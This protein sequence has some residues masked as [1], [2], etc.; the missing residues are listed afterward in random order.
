MEFADREAILSE[1][2]HQPRSSLI[3]RRELIRAA[4]FASAASALGAQFSFAQAIASGLTPAA[5]DED[6]STVLTDPNWK[7]VFLNDHQNE[8]LIAL[9]DVIIPS[10]DTPGATAALVN[11]YLDLLLSVQPVEFQKQ[12][13]DALA[14]IDTESQKQFAKTFPDLAR[15]DQI[16]LL[17]AWAYPSDSDRWIEGEGKADPGQQHFE[18]LKALIAAAFYGSE[19]GLKE[20]GW[21]GEF[22]HGPYEGCEHQPETHI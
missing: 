22:T 10:A 2:G 13:V 1:D 17:S 18:R 6:G 20:L 14:F 16:W 9:G 12:F 15:G 19:I 3:N 7:A 8:T 21:D 11:R 4:L 5:R